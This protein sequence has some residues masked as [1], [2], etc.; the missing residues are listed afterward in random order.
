MN[1]ICLFNMSTICSA[2][3]SM[4]NTDEV[5]SHDLIKE[6][7]RGYLNRGYYNRVK[8]FLSQNEK[9]KEF[10]DYLKSK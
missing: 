3:E 8:S 9:V 7:S 6:S 4:K 10:D 1:M 2:E 5:K